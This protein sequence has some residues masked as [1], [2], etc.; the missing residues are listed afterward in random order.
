MDHAPKDTVVADLEEEQTDALRWVNE[1]RGVGGGNLDGER[2]RDGGCCLSNPCSIGGLGRSATGTYLRRWFLELI[3]GG[4]FTPGGNRASFLVLGTILAI[5][6]LLFVYWL[7]QILW[8]IS[9]LISNSVS[10][11][12]FIGLGLGLGLSRFQFWMRR[13]SGSNSVEFN[14]WAWKFMNQTSLCTSESEVFKENIYSM[15]FDVPQFLPY[16]IIV[17]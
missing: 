4:N 14:N 17:I 5:F 12:I 2:W 10:A 9:K 15:P 11:R 13:Y 8:L 3:P 7:I 6:V 1:R 16:F